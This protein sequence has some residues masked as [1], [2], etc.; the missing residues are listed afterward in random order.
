MHFLSPSGQ[1]E[2]SVE[3]FANCSPPKV[4]NAYLEAL[5]T[6]AG[7]NG[8]Y[9]A[10]HD[11]NGRNGE[12]AKEASYRTDE[13]PHAGAASKRPA[14]ARAA[15]VRLQ[16][17]NNDLWVLRLTVPDEVASAGRALFDEIVPTFSPAG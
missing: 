6:A 17:Q 2:L 9:L 5:R 8:T 3:R 4:I 10:P 11:V 14:L 1:Q 7:T 13:T 16:A 15:V 12:P